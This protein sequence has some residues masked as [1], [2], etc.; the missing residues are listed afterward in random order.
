MGNITP[1]TLAE[2]SNIAGK[3]LSFS[4]PSNMPIMIAM[5]TATAAA[6]VGVKTPL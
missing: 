1:F 5:T 4:V 3:S 2:L 6:S